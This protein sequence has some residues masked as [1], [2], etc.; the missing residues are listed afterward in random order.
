MSE[1]SRDGLR[2]GWSQTDLTPGRPVLVAGQ[3]HARVS[4]SVLDPITATALALESAE[5]GDHAVL[6]SCDLVTISDELRDAVR[7]R[8]K[9]RAPGLDPVKVFL[10]GTHTHTGPEVRVEKVGAANV[11]GRLGIELDVTDPADYLAFAAERIA[12]SVEQAWTSRAPG[13][14]S[15]GLGHAVVGHNRRWTAFDGVSTMYGN[16]NA[17][18]FSHIEGY[19][20]HSVNLLCTWD[21]ERQLT[22]LVVNLACPSQVSESAFVVSADYWHETRQEL[23]RRLGTGLFVLPQCSAAGDQSPHHIIGR[24]TEDRMLKL[25][26]R[27]QREEIG[28]RIADVV[29]TILPHL[30]Q[31]IA[32]QPAFA[33][34]VETVEISR[35]LLTEADVTEALAE[36]QRHR[37][38]YEAARRE[39]ESKP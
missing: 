28:A 39:L 18:G 6:V 2:I 10:N 35:R 30:Q 14:V 27:T 12:A 16:T 31:D 24:A 21:A 5:A 34:R 20:D 19:E 17:P 3:F 37:E 38:C 1:P 36:A 25:K 15:F 33:H 13:G 26:G 7:E 11:S 23:R 9:P 4:E 22:G 32:W 29:M 8:L